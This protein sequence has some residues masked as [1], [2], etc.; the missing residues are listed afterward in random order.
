LLKIDKYATVIGMD[1]FENGPETARLDILSRQ[2]VPPLARLF[3]WYIL[4]PKER[5]SVQAGLLIA[6]IKPITVNRFGE[7]NVGVELTV[8]QW[9]GVAIAADDLART[10]RM[11]EDAEVYG[12]LCDRIADLPGYEH[13]PDIDIRT[14]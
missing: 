3:H 8:D 5:A 11:R 2:K 13:Q 10:V 14:M 9:H 7:S 4:C 1:L 12:E 6:R